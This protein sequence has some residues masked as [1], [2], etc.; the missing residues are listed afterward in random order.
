[1]SVVAESLLKFFRGTYRSGR[2]GRGLPSF[3][4]P[5][6]ESDKCRADV[7]TALAVANEFTGV[8]LA[9]QPCCGGR[10][11]VFLW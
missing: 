5:P 6:G 9:L 2:N 3:H 4:S 11:G 7:V 10:W 1:M 8:G